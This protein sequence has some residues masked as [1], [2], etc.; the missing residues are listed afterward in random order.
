M[1]ARLHPLFPISAQ[2]LAPVLGCGTI[3]AAGLVRCECHLCQGELDVSV[4]MF[5][6]HSGSTARR[7]AQNTY[8]AYYS[9]SLVVRNPRPFHR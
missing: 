1:E 4:S 2:P 3:T 6:E 7:P 8:L 5:E 9:M